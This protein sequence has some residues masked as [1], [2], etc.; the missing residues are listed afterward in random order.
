MTNKYIIHDV[1][2]NIRTSKGLISIKFINENVNVFSEDIL[3][4]QESTSDL[5]VH[6]ISGPILHKLMQHL[7][8][9]DI[10]LLKGE[11]VNS[12][13]FPLG[14]EQN[15]VY[16]EI[17]DAVRKSELKSWKNIE[18]HLN[19]KYTNYLSGSIKNRLAKINNVLELIGYE[20]TIRKKL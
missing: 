15:D 19:G 4:L 13:E 7:N 10:S 5:V 20:L 17:K 3:D 12:E 1:R 8:V 18:S 6:Q 9:T 14:N 16:Y 2:Y 11:I